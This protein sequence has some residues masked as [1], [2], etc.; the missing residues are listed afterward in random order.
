MTLPEEG[1]I[2][3]STIT[4]ESSH[5]E[6]IN[7]TPD[8]GVAPGVVTRPA[9]DTVVTLTATATNGTASEQREFDVTVR[10]AIAPP[11]TTDYL[12]AHF[13]GLE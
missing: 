6:I 11:E 7:V 3:R 10:A 8:G 5:P 4:W 12:F 1:A 2:Y 9:S 13:T